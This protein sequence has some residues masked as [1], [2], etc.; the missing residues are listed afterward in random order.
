M[1]MTLFL[2]SLILKF[3]HYLAKTTNNKQQT[4]NNKQNLKYET[5]YF[6]F[7]SFLVYNLTRFAK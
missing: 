2:S 7:K 4:T 5:H 1:D 6:D 3:V